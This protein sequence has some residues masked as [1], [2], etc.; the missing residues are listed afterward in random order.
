VSTEPQPEAAR[1][2]RAVSGVVSLVLCSLL[3]LFLL[4]DAVLRGGWAQTLLLTPWVLLGLWVVYELA[5]VS[6]VRIDGAGVVVQNMLRRTSFG[7]TRVSDIDFRWQ[8]VFSLEDD[9]SVTCYGGPARARPARQSRSANEVVKAPAGLRDLTEIRDRWQA[10]SESADS[11]IRRGWDAKA[12][13]ALG[14]I[15]ATAAVSVAIANS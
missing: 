3:A 8:L 14:V 7:W 12:L 2:F 11:P 15:L 4:G 9:T 6:A 1:T 13:I 10:A 5:F